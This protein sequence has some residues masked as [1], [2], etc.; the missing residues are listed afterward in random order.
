MTDAT[1][2]TIQHEPFYQATGREVELY[3]LRTVPACR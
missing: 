1:Q 2:Y 3:Q